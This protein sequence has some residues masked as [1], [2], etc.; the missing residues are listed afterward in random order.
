MEPLRVALVGA[1]A[2][3]RAH[4]EA[5]RSTPS[6]ELRGIFDLDPARAR[7]MVDAYGGICYES[8]DDLLAD[9]PVECVAVLVPPDAHETMTVE[10]LSAGRHVV[11]EK[12]LGRTVE[13]CDRMMDAASAAGRWLLPG[14]N[15]VFT[16]A[17]ER[18]KQAIDGGEIGTV[19][20]AQSCGLE[21]PSLLDGVPWLRTDRSLG[22]VLL[23][24]AVHPAYVLRWLLGPVAAVQALAGQR[25]VVEMTR[26][27]TAVVNLQLASGGV[28][29]MTSTFAVGHGPSHHA[30]TLYGTAG[31]LRSSMGGGRRERLAAVLPG[32][33]GD[34][35]PHDIDLGVQPRRWSA[36]GR[37]WDEYALAI[38]TGR[39]P[40]MSAAEGRAAV[41]VIRAAY[42]S[43]ER[44]VT[45]AID[46]PPAC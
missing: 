26:E 30:I 27:D 28:A 40:R 22:G 35:D 23:A 45:V 14:H 10:A 41:Q 33:F 16:P 8:W 4:L 38:R 42:E 31:Y 24:Q 15:R 20:L 9:R 6:V 29:T 37:M 1:G 39:Q 44:G 21:R 7:T 17:I 3:A 32:A 18:M 34:Q 5:L 11:C 46:D 36:F 25:R 13:E 43:I 2:I 12:P 19:F